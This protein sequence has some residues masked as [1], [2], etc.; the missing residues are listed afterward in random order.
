MRVALYVRVSTDKQTNDSQLG[1]L[2]EYC[3]RRNWTNVIEY[4][5]VIS[6]AGFR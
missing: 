6:G 1:E 5:D 2:R 4:R 3:H